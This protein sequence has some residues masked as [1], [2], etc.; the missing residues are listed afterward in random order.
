VKMPN[1]RRRN[2]SSKARRAGGNK[3]TTIR[4]RMVQ[5][6]A[7]SSL[8]NLGGNTQSVAFFTAAELTGAEIGPTQKAYFRSVRVSFI[9]TGT[10]AALPGGAAQVAIFDYNSAN[11]ASYDAYVPSGPYKALASQRPTVI[12]ASLTGASQEVALDGGNAGGLVAVS[13]TAYLACTYQLL[14]STTWELARDQTLQ[15]VTA[16]TV[17]MGAP[18]PADGSSAT[19]L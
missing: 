13:L 16:R 10:T 1:K 5:C 11:P 7:V 6:Q 19:A 17:F 18:P 8:A 14:I 15:S 12:A 2:K 9:L 3:F 4:G